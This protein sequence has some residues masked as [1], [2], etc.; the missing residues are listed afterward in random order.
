[1]IET[2][3]Y[4]GTTTE[5]A[6]NILKENFNMPQR[7]KYN[8]WLGKGVYFFLEDIFAFKWCVHEYRRKYKKDFTKE[9]ADKMSILEVKLEYEDERILDLTYFKGQYIFD[10]VY[11]EIL[12]SKKYSEELKCH[13]DNIV[14]IVIDYMFEILNFYEFYDVVKQIYRINIKNYSGILQT[15]ERG[16]P[17]LQICVKNL[18]IIKNRVIFDYIGNINNY[19][20]QWNNLINAEPF[21]N[22]NIKQDNEVDIH[23]IE[24]T[25]EDKIVYFRSDENE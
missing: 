1:M 23:E 14:C 4:H 10:L 19:I 7:K 25:G 16:M 18:N 9:D 13:P 20:E 3:G 2:I 22:V 11:K 15:R 6:Q 8:Y 5:S 12:K 24:Y 21:I 17:Q